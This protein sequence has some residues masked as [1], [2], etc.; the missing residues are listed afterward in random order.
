MVPELN[1]VCSVVEVRASISLIGICGRLPSPSHKTRCDG[2]YS[3]ETASDTHS[4]VKLAA[5]RGKILL[6]GRKEQS[7][8]LVEAL[9]ERVEFQM[10]ELTLGPTFGRK[11]GL[12]TRHARP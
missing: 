10:S 11:A 8:G 1:S 7:S 2:G 5:F 6:V 4:Q 9:R 3:I 12:P